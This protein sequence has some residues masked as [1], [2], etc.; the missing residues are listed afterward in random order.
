M[1]EKSY[2]RFVFTRW[3]FWFVLI[4]GFLGAVMAPP[5]LLI[6]RVALFSKYIGAPLFYALIIPSAIYFFKKK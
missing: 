3:Y 4:F 2:F 5:S 6:N 1:A